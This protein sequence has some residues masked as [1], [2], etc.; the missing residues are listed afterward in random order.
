MEGFSIICSFPQGMVPQRPVWWR[1]SAGSPT[2]RH[3]SWL[4]RMTPMKISNEVG[5][6][7]ETSRNPGSLFWAIPLPV[8]QVLKA[9]PPPAGAH[10]AMH[11]VDQT[12]IN[13][14]WRRWWRCCRDQGTVMDRLHL[15]NME[16]WMDAHRARELQPYCNGVDD[17]LYSKGSNVFRCHLPG[18]HMEGQVSGGE[19]HSL[20]RLVSRCRGAAAVGGGSVA[21]HRPKEDGT[22]LEPGSAAAVDEGLDRRARNFLLL[23]GEQR[24][25][26]AVCTLE[27]RGRWQSR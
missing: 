5:V 6:D 23:G 21:V 20:T 13:N 25:L 7:D 16:G 27:R 11:R 2:G 26:I 24:W 10:Q 19:P 9:S 15:G 18:F 8:H 12:P 17:F 1:Q 14:A 22:G 3:L 4:V